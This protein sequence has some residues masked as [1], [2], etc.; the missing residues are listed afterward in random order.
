VQNLSRFDFVETRACA[1]GPAR[2]GEPP[3][4][5]RVAE[6]RA[7]SGG[8]A[9]AKYV[10]DRGFCVYE[11]TW[12]TLAL[13]QSILA[14]HLGLAG[15]VVA[16]AVERRRAGWASVAVGLLAGWLA[17][18]FSEYALHRWL[19]HH[20]RHRVL[21]RI[22]WVGFHREHHGYP[23]MKDPD[24]HGVHVAITLP[25]GLAIVLVV[26]WASSSALALA[27]AAGWLVGYCGY[28]ALHWLFHSATRGHV[29]LRVR[30]LRALWVAH[31]VHHLHHPDSNFGFSSLFW[32]R[33]FGTLAPVH[34]RAL[35]LPSR[36][37]D[38]GALA[39]S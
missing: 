24:H 8:T 38:G 26:G 32:D 33:R 31:G 2:R 12:W 35:G 4:G 36:S 16:W 39:V 9:I 29:L 18:T 34:R 10:D 22:F 11:G 23:T 20:R 37:R 1:L 13:P 5:S 28:E 30:P 7:D 6:R 14:C 15:V 3:P 19:L 17:W 25:I 27:A 21:R